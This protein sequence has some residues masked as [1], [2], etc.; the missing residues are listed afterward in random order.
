MVRKILR[1]P[2]GEWLLQTAAGSAL[3]RMVV[4]L[5]K[6][7]GFRTINVVRRKETVEP[8]RS[9]GADVVINEADES[10]EERVRAVTGG[11]GVRFAIDAV[12]GTTGSAAL[13]SLGPGGRMLVYGTLADQPLT[14]S[15]RTLMVGGK[16]VEGF[17]LSEWVRRQSPLGMLAL[18]RDISRLLR[19]GVLTSEIA[20][21][22]PLE[23]IT[24]AVR[25]ALEPG[26]AGKIL[27]RMG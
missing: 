14:V 21:S 12:G 16:R 25:H 10:V 3:G 19:A 18:F 7:L 8:L 11:E 4:R 24:P 15:P 26:R 27:L 9:L 13:R 20:A 1:V 22:Y 23:E 2:N 17:W 6:H 5:G